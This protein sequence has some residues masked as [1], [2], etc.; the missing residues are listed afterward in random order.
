MKPVTDRSQVVSR[1]SL[2][3]HRDTAVGF[4]EETGWHA[5]QLV[6]IA[7]WILAPGRVEQ[8]R[9]PY[10]VCFT[11]CTGWPGVV[12]RNAYDRQPFLV[13]HALE[14][15]QSVLAGRTTDLEE[16]RENRASGEQIRYSYLRPSSSVAEFLA[17]G[18]PVQAFYFSG[19]FSCC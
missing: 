5:S 15:W 4:N 14:K 19:G 16:G 10:S 12:L 6:C 2:D 7:Q 17:L 9:E 3:G 18:Y 8:H 11:E 13:G 1:E